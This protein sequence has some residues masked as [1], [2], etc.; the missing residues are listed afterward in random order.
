MLTK[1][2]CR[3]RVLRAGEN[4]NLEIESEKDT[5]W[6]YIFG[7]KG[8]HMGYGPVLIENDTGLICQTGSVKYDKNVI[9]EFG[10]LM[11]SMK[12]Q[13]IQDKFESWSKLYKTFKNVGYF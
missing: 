1:E 13:S 6:G 12:G 7:W 9:E 11:L 8:F 4:S 10:K 5:E 3:E 2:E